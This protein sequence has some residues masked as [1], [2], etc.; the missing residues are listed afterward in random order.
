M[1]WLY[2]R[3]RFG[4][5]IVFR[6]FAKEKKDHGKVTVLGCC[7]L[8]ASLSNEQLASST[9]R[10]STGGQLVYLAISCVNNCVSIVYSVRFKLSVVLTNL[11][12]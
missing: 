10:I 7:W 8:Q 9:G 12:T 2:E 5:K 3:L 6:D 11:D 4:A 1:T